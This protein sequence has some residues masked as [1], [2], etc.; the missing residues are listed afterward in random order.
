MVLTQN[1]KRE[2]KIMAI[3]LNKTNASFHIYNI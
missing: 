3:L 2:K 1:Q